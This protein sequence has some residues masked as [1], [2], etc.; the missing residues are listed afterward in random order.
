MVNGVVYLNNITID[1]K[2]FDLSSATE[3][4]KTQLMHIQAIDVEV[5]RMNTMLAVL[6]TAKGNY[7]R[8]LKQELEQPGSV[9]SPNPPTVI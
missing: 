7:V 5:A 4:A 1:N 9:E 6:H 2:V 8:A 3:V